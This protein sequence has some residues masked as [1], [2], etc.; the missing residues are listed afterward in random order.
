MS[1]QAMAWAIKQVL[2]THD[3]FVLLML[4][5]Y[6]S[7]EGGECYP[8]IGRL[9]ADTAL[10]KDSVIR[11]IKSLERQSLLTTTR[12]K[13]DGVNLPNVYRLHFAVVIGIDS[14]GVVAGS[15]Y[16]PAA[17]TVVAA[18]DSNQSL[19]LSL[20][21]KED[22]GAKDDS[23]F[24]LEAGSF[25]GL[26]P[27]Q[28]ARWTVAYPKADVTLEIERAACWLI[29]NPSNLPK[30]GKVLRFLNGWISREANRQQQ[31]SAQPSTARHPSA[32]PKTT[33]QR[34]AERAES[35]G[36]ALFPHQGARDE[37]TVVDVDAIEMP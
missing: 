24:D 29:C 18:S 27:Q 36:A 14:K 13:Q 28:I 19:N 5:N 34:S 2:P 32:A 21:K 31:A 9:A 3:K 33:R 15:G 37:R 12:R 11:A 8:S 10:S 30:Q 26:T 25:T 7:N 16:P 20:K 22:A 35:W 17:G 23:S 6:A 4:A 1:F